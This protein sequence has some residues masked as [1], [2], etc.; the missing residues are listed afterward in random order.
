[1]KCR[2]FSAVLRTFADLLDAAGALV[3]RDQII[4]FAVVFDA[5][6]TSSVS[7]LAKRIGAL[8]G[9]GT[10]GSPSLV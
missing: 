8:R 7:D 9:T 2:D 5:H 4:M 3:A 10:A 1:M 6:P